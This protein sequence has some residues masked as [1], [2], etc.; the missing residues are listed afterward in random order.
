MQTMTHKTALLSALILSSSLL[1]SCGKKAQLEYETAQLLS[2][3]TEKG[4]ELK[5]VQAE[6][7]AIGNLG[8]YNYPQQ[9]HLDQLRTRIKQLREET[10]SLTSDKA[11]AEKD[12]ELLQQELDTYRARHLK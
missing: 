3:A 8:Q 6:S 1:S 10:V 11:S 5:T 9:V 4:N 2:S 7:A 12:V